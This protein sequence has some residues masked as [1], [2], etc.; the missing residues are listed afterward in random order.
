MTVVY[1]T[2]ARTCTNVHERVPNDNG[3][4]KEKEKGNV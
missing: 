3:N 1:T 2:E 4:G